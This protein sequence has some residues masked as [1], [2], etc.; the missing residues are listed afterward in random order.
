MYKGL[1]ALCRNSR[2]SQK[3]TPS[4]FLL[5]VLMGWC[6]WYLGNHPSHNIGNRNRESMSILLS[7]KL[8]LGFYK[9]MHS[10]TC[11]SHSYVPMVHCTM[12]SAQYVNLS[13]PLW[14]LKTI[15]HLSKILLRE[16]ILYQIGCFFT[17]CVNGP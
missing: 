16:A 13:T 15:S 7:G 14:S 12:L 17:H 3:R 10:P 6:I 8:S 2:Y 11:K 1:E 9:F 4:T 5:D